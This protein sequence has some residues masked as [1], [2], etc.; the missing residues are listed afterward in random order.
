[1]P[2][3]KVLALDLDSTLLNDE[4][5]ISSVNQYWISKAKEAGVT[6][7]FTTGRGLTRVTHLLEQLQLT[8]PQVLLN[9]AEVWKNT[10][11][12]LDRSFLP[13]DIVKHMYNEASKYD[14]RIWAYNTEEI[15]RFNEIDQ[16]NVKWNFLKFGVSHS[17]EEVIIKLKE[18]F[19]KIPHITVTSSSRMNL[20]ISTKDVTKATGIQKLFNSLKISFKDVM[21]IGDNLNDVHLIKSAGLG[22][23][24]GNAIPELKSIAD[25][26]TLSNEEDGVAKAIQNFLL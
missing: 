25:E 22:V 26:V 5:K 9:G 17:K 3:Y 15:V 16:G 20:E 12:L 18:E 2:K 10:N 21:A 23:A 8:G 7:M 4:K 13:E 6:V 11:Q 1:M 24:M 14:T 19:L